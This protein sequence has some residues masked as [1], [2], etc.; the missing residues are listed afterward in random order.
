MTS[1][2]YEPDF[3]QYLA[4]NFPEH[5]NRILKSHSRAWFSRIF[6]PMIFF[7]V[8]AAFFV[9]IAFFVYCI[10]QPNFFTFQNQDKFA[11]LVQNISLKNTLF[12]ILMTGSFVS[13]VCFVVGLFIGFSRAHYLLFEAEKLELS[14]KKLWLTEKKPASNSQKI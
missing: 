1:K 7:L 6:F 5:A 11:D 3:K 8:P 12:S 9:L 10:K 4:T 14:A 13:L 2:S